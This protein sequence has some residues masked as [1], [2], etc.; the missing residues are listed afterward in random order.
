MLTRIRHHG[1]P[2]AGR[3]A[4]FAGPSLIDQMLVSG[5][6]FVMAVVLA[7]LLGIAAFGQFSLMLIVMFF[8]IEVQ[9]S[10]IVSPMMTIGARL[11]QAGYLAGLLRAQFMTAFLLAVVA[12][13]FIRLSD[14]WY[15][16]W[17]VGGYAVEVGLM[18]FFR[19]TQEFLRRAL[20]MR[21]KG[22]EA[23][24]MD[25][26]VSAVIVIGVA[27]LFIRG[28]LNIQNVLLVHAAAYAVCL[29]G[30]RAL[31]RDAGAARRPKF[32]DLAAQHW[33]MGG[34]LL[35]AA[36]AAYASSNLLIMAGSAVLGSEAAGLI[37]AAQYAMGGMI[38]MFQAVDNVLPH[39]LAQLAHQ[40]REIGF[41]VAALKS[42]GLMLGFGVVHGA[43][44]WA[45]VGPVSAWLAPGHEVVFRPIL[46]LNIFLSLLLVLNYGMQYMFRARGHTRPI[47]IANVVT[48]AI[49]LVIG[50]PLA[51][52]FGVTGIVWGL[53]LIHMIVAAVFFCLGPLR[54]RVMS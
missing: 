29:A 41:R 40:G 46:L 54:P 49:S 48:A 2:L 50:K 16:L 33:Q 35:A 36:V 52:H 51:V 18:L 20:F 17:G 27:A 39:H 34:W 42:I 21:K 15:P 5:T 53:C 9:R 13:G 10:I 14:E 22:G 1:F 37:K 23:L 31:Q 19:M 30:Y 47:F 4:H 43:V 24:V 12:G 44:S 25:I 26:A 8:C 28:V 32:S 45:F 6:N 38:V 11:E 7:R 3:L